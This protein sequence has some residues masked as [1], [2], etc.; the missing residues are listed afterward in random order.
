MKPTKKIL[1]LLSIIIISLSS[2]YALTDY[3]YNLNKIN[4]T[5]EDE[6]ENKNLELY[7]ADSSLPNRFNFTYYKVITLNH[8]KVSGSNNLT[9]FPVL[10]S[11]LD[12][13]LHDDVQPDGD[14]IAFANESSWLDHEIELFNQD[15]SST[16][17]QLIA[18]V[19]IPLL[20]VT[21]DTNI[22]MYYGNPYIVSQENKTGVWDDNYKGVWH[23][24]EV[25]AID[26][27]SNKN[28]GTEGGGV[29]YEDEGKISDANFFT[30]ASDSFISIG[31]I[32]SEIKTIEFWMNPSSLGSGNPTETAWKSP[33]ATGDDY[34][35]WLTPENAHTSNDSYARENSSNQIQDWYNFNFDIPNGATIDNIEVNIEA[36]ASVNIGAEVALSWNGGVSYTNEK[37]NSYLS[38]AN[39]TFGGLLDPWEGHTWTSNDFENNNFRIRIQRGIQAS[40]NF[41]DVDWIA[42]KIY[43]TYKYMRI[44]D[45]DNSA[46]IE[47]VEGNLLA[48]NFPGTT[49]IYIDG[50]LDSSLTALTWQYV[51]VINTIGVN[52][53]D[54]E[55]GR[56]LPDYYTGTIDELRGSNISRTPDSINTTY[57]NQ[58]DPISFYNISQEIDFN[59]DPPSYSNLT[60]S[61]DELELGETEVISINVTDPS[62]I[63]NVTIE[64]ESSNNLMTN[65]G[66][67]NWSYDVWTPSQTGNYSYTIYMEDNTGYWNSVNDSI[68]VVDNTPP[69][70]SNL[71]ENADPLELGENITITVNASDLSGIN[72][73]L[74]EFGGPNE[75]MSNIGGDTWQY[76]LWSPSNTG[77]LNY[78]I[79]IEDNSGLWNS[80]SNSTTVVDRTSP[81]YSNL[82]ES[83]DPLQLGNSIVISIDA[84]DLSD[85]NAVLLEFGGFNETMS[86][87]GGDTWQYDLWT[88]SNTGI[89]NYTIYIEDNN[90]N[91]NSTGQQDFTVEDTTAPS[92]TGVQESDD[93]LEFGNNETI[94]FN[95]TDLSIPFAYIYLEFDGVN[96]S[97]SY[98]SGDLWE[99]TY[100]QPTSVGLK[101]YT[102][103]VEDDQGNIKE[104]NG[105]ITVQDTTE[106]TWDTL[107][108]NDDPLELGDTMIISVN[109]SDISNIHTVL[110]EFESVNHTM[111]NIVGDTWQ[112]DWVPTQT[113]ILN[114]T[115]YIEDNS[116][117]WNSVS[118]STTVVD[119]TSPTYS[120]LIE[121]ADPLEFG[122]N[123]VI[124]IDAS[125]FSGIFRVLIEFDGSNH[126]MVFVSGNTWRYTSWTPSHT[127]I[128]NFTIYIEDNKN[129][130]ISLMANITVQDTTPPS[131][132]T[133]IQA[134]SGGI[135]E[136]LTF[137]WESSFDYSGIS[138]YILIIDNESDPDITEGYVLYVNITNTGPES[139]YYELTEGL[140]AGT[141]YYFLSQIDGVGQQSDFITGSFEITSPGGRGNI[142]ILDL[143]PYILA[144]LIGSVTAIVLVRNRIQSR[145]HPKRKKILLKSIISH[146]NKISSVK[147]I[148][149]KGEQER[150]IDDKVI[151]KREKFEEKDLESQLI[152]SKTLGEELFEEGAYLEAQKQFEQIEVLL[153]KLGRNEEATDYSKRIL[154]I[155][156]LNE[157]REKKLELLEQEKLAKNTGNITNLYFD[158]IDIAKRLKDFDG[159]E[160]YQSELKQ[161]Y[162]DGI[163]TISDFIQ[164]RDIL[165]DEASIFLN[166]YNYQKAANQYEKCEDI[167]HFL[168]K[169]GREE[170][171][172]NI[173]KFRKKKNESKRKS[174][175]KQR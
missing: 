110:L 32:G 60:E 70:Y 53:T 129:Y 57:F 45:L 128:H 109:A 74:L 159:I 7:T 167:T 140:P 67:N 153:L 68:L 170:E 76:D 62:G 26:S 149:E 31:D 106:P 80:L 166:Q 61:S 64:Y 48:T 69:T 137:D 88:P 56:V 173:E 50:V 96:H 97:M 99:Y 94:Q 30:G 83:A 43:Y 121:S 141:Y 47:I 41:L 108:E 165:E 77:I 130:T 101:F 131:P 114:Y 10:I 98:V 155:G 113:G 39:K 148:L 37:T 25:N 2:I 145:L 117:L 9:N 34:T 126:S 144:I 164:K 143:L 104:Y 124:S 89:L 154:E 172:I 4:F 59:T 151:T 115:I 38:E 55:I 163:L 120:N 36:K 138:Y 79:Y 112:Y 84:I 42:I 46:R 49:T 174:E 157:E 162:D 139:S 150:E 13:D 132:P 52:V 160:M 23:M 19:R 169:L 29:L 119:T 72:T 175:Y 28:N 71:I 24:N 81:T 156:E 168:I 16:H 8:T 44:L 152:E 15:F 92:I 105:D 11:I 20:S 18:W 82:I 142:T 158:L 3:T 33:T 133:I 58:N 147:P 86:N 21:A 136:T 35:D 100:W 63:R 6:L 17:A 65:I 1:L 135:N 127:G 87:I 102:I 66:G 12:E 5:N 91:W 107:I 90:N 134:P 111:N 95:V 54:L 171:I 78:T 27:T 146:I 118:N 93:L 14:D 22:T 125:D 73:V 51:A 116:G 122:N 40:G 123:I 85:I 75:T 103:W 161:L